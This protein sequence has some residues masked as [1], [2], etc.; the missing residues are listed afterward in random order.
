MEDRK[1]SIQRCIHVINTYGSYTEKDIC[2]KL[3]SMTWDMNGI[4]PLAQQYLNSLAGKSIASIAVEVVERN[5]S[6]TDWF[7]DIYGGS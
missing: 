1:P 2:E 3:R 6:A 4:T 5:P 7:M